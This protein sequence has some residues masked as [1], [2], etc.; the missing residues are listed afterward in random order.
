MER[1]W[2]RNVVSR[3]SSVI[4]VIRLPISCVSSMAI[5]CHVAYQLFLWQMCNLYFYCNCVN[6]TC[7]AAVPNKRFW[8]W[9][10]RGWTGFNCRDSGRQGGPRENYRWDTAGQCAGRGRLRRHT[11]LQLDAVTR[12]LR[13][14]VNGQ[15]AVD[16][17]AR[18]TG[19]HQL[20]SDQS[21]HWP[22]RKWPSG[23]RSD[24]GSVMLLEI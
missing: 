2:E 7:I 21:D 14:T 5:S 20:Y 13:P 8:F 17:A 19:F 3:V 4:V 22:T 9:C 23:D 24:A 6:L 12:K 18:W 10:P 11:V 16:S 15:W 1:H